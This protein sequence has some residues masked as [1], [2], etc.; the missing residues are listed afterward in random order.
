[1]Q[2]VSKLMQDWSSAMGVFSRM[3]ERSGRWEALY[4]A[5]GG[6]AHD[7]M[8]ADF[9]PGG[10]K[11]LDIQPYL[12]QRVDIKSFFNDPWF[13]DL[14]LLKKAREL[15][16]IGGRG[17][18]KIT[19]NPLSPVRLSSSTLSHEYVH[20]RQRDITETGWDG[21]V[22]YNAIHYVGQFQKTLLARGWSEIK[23]G[24]V[25]IATYS[26]GVGS[27]SSYYAKNNEIQARMHEILATGFQ[28]WGKLPV[29]KIEFWAAM[30][31]FGMK[32]PPSVMAALDTEEGQKALRDFK[33]MKPLQSCRASQVSVFQDIERWVGDADVKEALWHTHY[34][35]IYGE[36]LEF[37][38]DIPGRAR[39]GLGHNPRP[40]IEV[41]AE[42]KAASD[43][44]S[45]ET[46]Q[47]LAAKIPPDLAAAFINNLIKR[48]GEHGEG[49]GNAMLVTRF[50]LERSDVKTALFDPP[51]LKTDNHSGLDN[52][53][54]LM[55]A[56]ERGHKGMVEMLMRAGANPFQKC[57][58]YDMRG[59]QIGVP[60]SAAHSIGSR[61]FIL[62]S[63][64]DPAQ[65]SSRSSRQYYTDPESRAQMIENL[66]QKSGALY[67]MMALAMEAGR[68]YLVEH[69]GK[70]RMLTFAQGLVTLGIDHDFT[71]EPPARPE[72]L[73]P[74]I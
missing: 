12:N 5:G 63:L 39:L 46:A 17:G 55:V 27:V 71:Q 13:Q 28:Q 64:D 68:Q 53:P 61:S 35:L 38:G 33:T 9:G 3:V 29:T 24:V 66:D 25:D 72:W 60:T 7:C 37:Y 20:T 41:M 15:G 16:F 51:V 36:L 18:E 6:H 21:L 43:D 47:E 34:P 45:E 31:N 19:V 23:R 2:N 8:E 32:L 50:L 30:A 62:E 73:D 49:H 56:V 14:S 40:A 4:K 58:M 11:N 54:P 69:K 26:P 57:D 42:L 74:V 1:M 48:Y 22:E 70:R 65:F 59:V 67:E 44:I 52:H 10:P